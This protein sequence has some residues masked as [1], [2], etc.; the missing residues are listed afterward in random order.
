MDSSWLQIA[1]AVDFP[2][3]EWLIT[4]SCGICGAESSAQILIRGGILWSKIRLVKP[5]H[6]VQRADSA[7]I[8]IGDEAALSYPN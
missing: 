8:R 5:L 6:W 7:E 2:S 1:L 3:I 4:T